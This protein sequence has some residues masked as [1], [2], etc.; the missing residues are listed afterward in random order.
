VV[1]GKGGG[2]LPAMSIPFRL[3]LG[4]HLGSGRQWMSWIH[5]ED[6][7]RLALFAVENLD[8]RGPLNATAPWPVRN[9]DFTQA[10]AKVLHRSTFLRA[11]AFA[12]RMIGELSHELLDSKRVLPAAALEHGY[13]FR[14]SELEPALKDLLG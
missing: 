11:P 8:L 3:G 1:L 10:L 14:F 4:G 7:A 5:L 9:A 2:A 6:I 12:I 13:G